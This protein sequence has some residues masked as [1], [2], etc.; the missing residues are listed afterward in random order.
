MS[1]RRLVQDLVEER[2][3]GNECFDLVDNHWL[4][5]KLDQGFGQGQGQWPQT[6]TK[7]TDENNSLHCVIV[8]NDTGGEAEE[9]K[10]S[11]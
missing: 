10:L 5:A 1:E 8:M 4:V 11:R 6:S 2:A 3:Y 9:E 7:P